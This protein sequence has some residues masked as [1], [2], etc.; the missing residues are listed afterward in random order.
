[1]HFWL[2]KRPLTLV[3][4]LRGSYTSFDVSSWGL[5]PSHVS[6]L[7][8]CLVPCST[9]CLYPRAGC[10]VTTDLLHARASSHSYTCS[11]WSPDHYSSLSCTNRA[12][13]CCRQQLHSSLH[14]QNGFSTSIPRGERINQQK[15]QRGGR[16][17]QQMSVW[18][19]APFSTAAES[20][21]LLCVFLP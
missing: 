13:S 14:Q 6:W 21:I 12:F 15:Y 8:P 7:S 2:L 4:R 11:I 5:R 19:P 20:R 18:I 17:G 16:K 10:T 9:Y 1:M 3:S